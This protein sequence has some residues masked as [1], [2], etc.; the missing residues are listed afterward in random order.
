MDEAIEAL[1]RAVES[2]GD[3]DPTNF[4]FLDMAHSRRGDKEEG[5]RFLKRGAGVA[6]ERNGQQ[7]GMADVLGGSGCG[8]G[9]NASAEGGL[10]DLLIFGSAETAEDAGFHRRPDPFP[11]ISVG[12]KKPSAFALG[13]L[14]S[15]LISYAK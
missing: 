10:M 7:S 4:F 12:D 5:Q 11:V 13:A 6:K 9:R 1:N 15:G 2:D 8:F 3:T 14:P